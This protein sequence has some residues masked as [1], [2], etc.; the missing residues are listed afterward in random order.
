[1]APAIYA[2]VVDGS[3]ASSWLLGQNDSPTTSGRE[4]QFQHAT[5][6]ENAWLALSE[7]AGKQRAQASTVK[8]SGQWTASDIYSTTGLMSN[9]G[10]SELSA[11]VPGNVVYV[12]LTSTLTTDYTVDVRIDGASHSQ[13]AIPLPVLRSSRQ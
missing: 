4:G 3:F 2:S 12:G 1:M 9:T 6:A 8:Q 5:L 11:T 10:G 13:V 7:G